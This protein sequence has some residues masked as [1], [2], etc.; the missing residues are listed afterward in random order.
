M[1]PFVYIAALRRSGS[2]LLAGAL[3][4]WPQTY[5]FLEPQLP[6]G[7]LRIG[8]P[9]RLRL[10]EQ[11]VEL[12]T[13][14]DRHLREDQSREERQHIIRDEIFATLQAASVVQLGIK[15]IRHRHWQ[16]I[17]DVFGNVR[18]VLL[19]RDPRDVYISLTRR[20]RVKRFGFKGEITPKSVAADLQTEFEFQ[21]AMHE[22]QKAM[23]VRYES[24]CTQP[25][26]IREVQQFIESPASTIGNIDATQIE[27]RHAFGNEISPDHIRR[28]EHEPEALLR[29]E[30]D[31][32]FELLSDFNEFW[33]Y[34]K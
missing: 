18:F 4:S 22:S 27:E 21:R 33:E 28:F 23:K 2:K 8:E 12:Q 7:W 15:E 26:L 5:I 11:S 14:I 16:T 25:E 3:T 17:P 9:D 29:S 19:A 31:A 10:A 32:C 1:P 34:E 6:R 13:L 20:A 30:A 24:L